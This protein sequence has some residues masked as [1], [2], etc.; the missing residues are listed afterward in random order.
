MS[1]TSETTVFRT[2]PLCEAT[3]G[4]AITLSDNRVISIRGD[5]DDE[6]SR[7]YICPKGAVLNKLH[8]DPDRLRKPLIRKGRQWTEV[9]WETAFAEVEKGLSAAKKQYGQDAVAVY[10]G[11]PNTHTIASIALAPLL[12]SIRSKNTYS[13]SSVDQLPKQMACG[14]MYGNPNTIPIPDIDRTA[15]L[16]IIGANPLASNGSLCTAP[17]FPGRLKAIRS[18]GGKIVVVDPKKTAT[19]MMADEHHFI[20]PGTDALLLFAMIRTLFENNRIKLGNIAQLING[21]QAVK[22]LSEP[23]APEKV[24]PLCGIAAPEIRRMAIELADADTAVVYGR[25]GAS[26]VLFGGLTNWLVDVLNIITGNFDKSGGAM[27]TTP[28]HL[29]AKTNK[30]GKEFRVGRWKSRIQNLP[31]IL[32]EFPVATLADEIE[33]S[34]EGQIRS[35]ICITGNPVISNP[36]SRRLDNALGTLDFMVS[37]DFYLNETSRHAHVILPPT[38]Q[39][40]QG[41]YDFIFNLFSVRN[42]A[43]YSKP[44]IPVEPDEKSFW[45]ILTRLTLITSG[46]GASADPAALDEYIIKQMIEANLKLPENKISQKTSE[47]I[48]DALKPLKGPER[49][50]DFLLRTGAYGNG[51]DADSNGL[52][53]QKL[54]DNPH[55]IDLGPLMPRLPEILSTSSGKIELAPQFITD[56]VSRLEAFLNASYKDGFLLIGRRDLKSNNSWMHNIPALVSGKLRCTLQINTDDAGHL[57]VATGDNVRI[58]SRVGSITAPVEVTND[59]MPGVVSLPH[60]WGHDLPDIKIRVAQAN[61]GIN[62]N[63]LADEE[64]FDL[65]SGNSVLN[66]IP[67]EIFPES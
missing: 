23:F 6:F 13:S 40:S 26:T 53:F 20:R 49:M 36:N 38:S 27:F 31:E 24:S 41:H 11:N 33:T 29:P 62:S 47:E 21:L 3:C 51:F 5:Q 52:S 19:A 66:G 12:K 30:N 37:V 65:L 39:L 45:E 8:E 57:G 18:R 34:G 1:E 48:L 54:I 7:G 9:S 64:S 42:T 60:G 15:H 55:G 32:G 46:M 59:L 50:L 2:C 17:D 28:A 43:K 16:L 56:D 44:V 14:L 22:E 58:K 61:A 10:M 4:L 63:I 67:V 35:L 25:M